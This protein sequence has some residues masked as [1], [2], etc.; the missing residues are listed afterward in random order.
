MGRLNVAFQGKDM[1]VRAIM[2]VLAS[3]IVMGCSD[4]GEAFVTPNGHLSA[5]TDRRLYSVGDNIA[6]VL[7]NTS[8]STVYFS[9]C[10][11]RIGFWIQR[12]DNERWVDAGSFNILCLAIYPSGR[13]PFPPGSSAHD[14]I[15]LSARGTYWLLFPFAWLENQRV[16]NAI[17][18]NEFEVR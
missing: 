18:S 16:D 14:T 7:K 12:K 2:T 15:S 5:T 4:A 1:I 8:P 3:L 6:M 11:Y 13:T 9:H 10:N 17:L